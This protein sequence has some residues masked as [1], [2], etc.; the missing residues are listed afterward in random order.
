MTDERKTEALLLYM[1]KPAYLLLFIIPLFLGC[2][3]SQ[4]TIDNEAIQAYISANHLNATAEANGLYFVPISGGNGS[5]ASSASLVTVTY[6]G[7]LTNGAVFDQQ[8]APTTFNLAEVI[9]G[10]QEGI[11][12]MQRGQTAMLLVPSSLGYGSYAQPANGSYAAIPANSV[13]IFTVNLISF[14]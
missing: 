13:L 14:Q 10:W 1:R 7:T 3:K 4:A 9:S 8:G 6:K 12:L 2:K 11:P 5:Y